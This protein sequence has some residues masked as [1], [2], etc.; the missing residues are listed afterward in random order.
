[1]KNAKAPHNLTHVLVY[2]QNAYLTKHGFKIQKY[3]IQNTKIQKYK[4][5]RVEGERPTGT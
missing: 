3:K 1:M 4:K 2:D 5:H